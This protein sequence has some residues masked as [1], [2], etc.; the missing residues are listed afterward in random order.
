MPCTPQSSATAHRE[1]L[2]AAP[3]GAIPE[4]GPHS[5]PT[6]VT[7]PMLMMRPLRRGINGLS[8]DSLRHEE[9]TRRLVSRQ[10]VFQSSHVTSTGGLAAIA[11][12]IVDQNVDSDDR[13][14]RSPPSPWPGCWRDP[15]RQAPVAAPA[16]PAGLRFPSGRARVSRQSRLVMMRYRARPGPGRA[17]S[18]GPVRDWSPSTNATFP[19][20]SNNGS[21]M[22]IPRIPFG[23]SPAAVQ[24]RMGVDLPPAAGNVVPQILEAIL[25]GQGTDVDAGF[26]GPEHMPRLP[27]QG[28]VQP[29][30]RRRASASRRAILSVRQSWL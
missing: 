5:R 26:D 15:A 9:C 30:P 18:T 14:A 20:K 19:V 10:A 2:H 27:V 13:S 7:E 16:G 25:P 29:R 12:G 24:P 22:L 28:T 8:G 4:P 11:A 6:Q 23:S 21:F 1:L 3:A 17:R